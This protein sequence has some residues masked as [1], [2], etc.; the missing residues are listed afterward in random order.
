MIC[1][2]WIITDDEFLYVIDTDNK[3]FP[4]NLKK[5]LFYEASWFLLGDII[6][7]HGGCYMNRV[8]NHP[9]QI[10]VRSCWSKR[11]QFPKDVYTE[12]HDLFDKDVTDINK[13]YDYYRDLASK[14]LNCEWPDK[15]SSGNT[16]KFDPNSMVIQL[17]LGLYLSSLN[18]EFKQNLID[19]PHLIKDVLYKVHAQGHDDCFFESP[20]VPLVKN[21]EIEDFR[22]YLNIAVNS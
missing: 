3:C 21:Y 10:I 22:Y 15:I 12:I 18:E 14:I 8:I 20:I 19:N 9:W 6:T 2:N 5:E 13:S 16:I 4:K 11:C 17:G 1:G 7:G